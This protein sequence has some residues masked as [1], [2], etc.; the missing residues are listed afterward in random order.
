MHFAEVES[1][2]Y[3]GVLTV[4]N[5]SRAD[6]KE[7]FVVMKDYFVATQSYIVTSSNR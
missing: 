7:C 2:S 4:T 6:S 5:T 3:S 1:N